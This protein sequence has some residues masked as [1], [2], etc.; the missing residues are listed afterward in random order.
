MRL[1]DADAVRDAIYGMHVNGK[2]G[3]ENALRNTYGADLREVLYEID[4]LPTVCDIEQIKSD[5]RNQ[6]FVGRIVNSKDFDDG[7]KWCLELI[8]EYTKGESE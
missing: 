5:I 2:E 7:L 6:L 8:E 1:I 4:E 3:V